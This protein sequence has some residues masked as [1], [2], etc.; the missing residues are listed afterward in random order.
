MFL[1]GPI[2]GRPT[3][4]NLE[5]L[6]AGRDMLPNPKLPATIGLG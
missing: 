5:I 6:R 3:I 2:G 1:K 4:I